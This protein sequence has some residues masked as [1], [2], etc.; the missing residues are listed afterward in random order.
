MS[1]A[2]IPSFLEERS[3]YLREKANG[4]YSAESFLFANFLVSL[5]FVLLI[6]VGFSLTAYFLIGYQFV[7]SKLLIFIG[8]V[9]VSLVVSEAQVVFFATLHPVFIIALTI[10]SFQNGL[11]MIVNGIAF[12]KASDIPPFWRFGFHYTNF[13]KYGYEAILKNEMEG[14]SFNCSTKYVCLVPP[15]DPNS[16]Y[17]TG[18][19]LIVYY[20]HG[21]VQ[22]GLWLLYLSIILLVFK[23]LTYL[24]LKFSGKTLRGKK[25]ITKFAESFCKFSSTE[26]FKLIY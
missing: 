6:T 5:P 14:I 23:L 17:F 1:V 15:T 12:I 18:E 25:F 19:E 8:Y 24:V 4:L 3:V 9:F 21:N 11:W 7:L 13:Q 26:E 16:G 10:T 2:G 22:Y 20:E